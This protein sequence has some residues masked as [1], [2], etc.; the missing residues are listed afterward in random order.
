MSLNIKPQA[1][2]PRYPGSKRRRL[3]AWAKWLDGYRPTVVIEPF[4]GGLWYS[5][6][7]M[8]SKNPAR[9][10]RFAEVQGDL[11]AV[12]RCWFLGKED[13]VRQVVASWQHAFATEDPEVVWTELKRVFT[14]SG[15]AVARAGASLCLRKLTMSGVTRDTPGSGELNVR[16][17]KTQLEPLQRYVPTFP[18]LVG[19]IQMKPDFGAVDWELGHA[20]RAIAIIDPPYSGEVLDHRVAPSRRSGK[21]ISPAYVGHRPHARATQEMGIKALDQAMS[22]RVQRIIMCNYFSPQLD[23]RFQVAAKYWGYTLHCN[24]IGKLTTLNNNCRK[25]KNETPYVDTD[26]YFVRN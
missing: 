19:S 15:N 21:Y 26:W 10:Y 9:E 8:Q 6:G 16:Y 23:A 12:Y 20:D 5:L 14:H 18:P 24:L 7:S 13:E 17:V 2:I 1:L 11:Q 22:H 3:P 25:A 4:G